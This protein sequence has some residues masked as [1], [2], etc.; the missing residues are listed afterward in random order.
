M[1]TESIR[2]FASYE[3]LLALG[4]TLCIAGVVLRGLHNTTR[5][6]AVLRRQHAMLERQEGRPDPAAQAGQKPGHWE[7][8]LRLYARLLLGAGLLLTVLAFI[9]K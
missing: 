1:N 8:H 9:R 2:Q 3:M 4:M 7:R 6:A 5:R